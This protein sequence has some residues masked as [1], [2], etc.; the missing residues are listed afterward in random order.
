MSQPK[1]PNRA[2]SSFFKSKTAARKPGGSAPLAADTSSS[3][4]LFADLVA[5]ESVYNGSAG[6]WSEAPSAALDGEGMF[7]GVASATP[8][9]APGPLVLVKKVKVSELVDA[10][11]E[12]SQNELRE[13]IEAEETRQKLLVAQLHAQQAAEEAEAAKRAGGSAAAAPAAAATAPKTYTEMLAQRRAGEAAGGG[14]AKA[15]PAVEGVKDGRI[16][17]EDTRAFPSLGPAL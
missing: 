8:A 11:A 12:E 2:V 5:P 3:S 6:D 9:P 13:R 4:A 10:V 1:A 17:S 15:A 16:L 14:S 7:A